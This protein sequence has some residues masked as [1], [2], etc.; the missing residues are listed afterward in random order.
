MSE[1][2]QSNETKFQ[3]TLKSP[4]NC[5][6]IGLH[7]GSKVSM[8]LMP[9]DANTGIVFVRTDQPA[10]R[11]TVRADWDRVTDTKLCTVISNDAG[12][13]IGTI[14]HLMAALRG[15]GIDNAVIELNGPEVP[16]MDGSS[17]PFVFLIECAGI[18][19]QDKPRRLIKILKQVTVGDQTRFASLTPSPVTGFS[20]EI[21]FASAAVARQETYVKLGSG[22]FKGE[23]ARARTFGF[24]HEV[25]QM[26]KLGLARGGS[27]DNA[28]VINGDKVLNE[29][30]LR[31]SDEFVRHK[32][33]DSIGDLYLAGAPI[34]GHFH[35]C[36]SG[37]ALN[38]QLLR[39]LF[40]DQS[41]WCYV[42]ADEA[43]A[44]P[45]EWA[46]EKI[47]AVA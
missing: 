46:R 33:L 17:A 21:D 5:T 32:I 7:S 22:T 1:Q 19:Q 18:R 37:H 4:I 28:I 42:D 12:V 27:L 11:A 10:D 20:F 40:A 16:I 13:S 15:C 8:R 14:E 30:G 38:N 43:G 2:S 9:S 29:G 34:V 45:A 47:A 36:R 31:Y 24:L 35:G 23:L 41:A 3:Q 39:A 44:T 26:R 25:D 6:G